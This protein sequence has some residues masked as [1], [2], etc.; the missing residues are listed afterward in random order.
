MEAGR[1]G[2]GDSIGMD[3]FRLLTHTKVALWMHDLT[4]LFSII[5]K[6]AVMQFKEHKDSIKVCV[7]CAKLSCVLALC[8]HSTHST[9]LLSG[10]L[11]T[12]ENIHCFLC[13]NI[14]VLSLSFVDISGDGCG[15]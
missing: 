13:P 10:A 12:I 3:I 9:S 1:E 8:I 15:W 7:F 2:S 5:E 11:I 6:R 4:P 14:F